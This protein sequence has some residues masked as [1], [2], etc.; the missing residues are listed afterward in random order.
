[1]NGGG[2]RYC[3]LHTWTS[4]KIT[5]KDYMD[6]LDEMVAY[7]KRLLEIQEKYNDLNEENLGESDYEDDGWIIQGG[8][9]VSE[10]L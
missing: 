7:N 9:D 10:I 5:A 2:D 3:L 6:E 8:S 1:M 4:G